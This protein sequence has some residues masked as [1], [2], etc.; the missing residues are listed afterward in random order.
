VVR[1]HRASSQVSVGA[2]EA[3]AAARRSSVPPS[4]DVVAPR[5]QE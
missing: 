5:A 4:T 2:R 3:P 1:A